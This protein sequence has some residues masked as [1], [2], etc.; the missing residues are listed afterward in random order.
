M[1]PGTTTVE[2]LVRRVQRLAE[3]RVERSLT[4]PLTDQHLL[5][6]PGSGLALIDA[7]AAAL[8]DGVVHVDPELRRRPRLIWLRDAPVIASAKSLRKVLDRL[9]YA[10][11]TTRVLAEYSKPVTDHHAA[12]E[13]VRVHL[14]RGRLRVKTAHLEPQAQGRP[15]GRMPKKV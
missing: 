14:H 5:D 8:L 4:Q 9:T 6:G 7:L 11:K 3:R 13:A 1:A 2:R 12:I 15:A 10:Q